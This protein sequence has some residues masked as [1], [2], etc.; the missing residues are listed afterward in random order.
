MDSRHPPTARVRFAP[1]F[2]ARVASFALAQAANRRTPR[3]D[4]AS[5]SAAVAAGSGEFAGR[6]RYRPGDDLRAFDWEAFARGGGEHVRLSRR[7]SGERWSVVLDSSASMAIGLPEHPPKIQLAAELALALCAVGLCA[8]GQVSLATE[9][10]ILELR[11]QADLARAMG[12]LDGLECSGSLGFEPWFRHRALARASRCIAIG[13][14][15]DVDPAQV[16]LHAARRRRMDAVCVLARVELAPLAESESG[17]SVEWRDP[18]SGASL[19]ARLGEREA[20][21]YSAALAL[22]H[23]H[24]RASLARVGGELVIARAGDPFEPHAAQLL[25]GRRA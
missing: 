16:A 15:F 17:S 24:W 25:R 7:E 10:G 6:R 19:V 23:R 1:G 21:R 3:E 14:L 8:G 9:R 20:A 12:A 22:H 18:E 13:D 11:S 2:G 5:S 4:F